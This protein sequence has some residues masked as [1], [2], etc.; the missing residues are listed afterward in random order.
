MQHRVHTAVSAALDK[1]AFDLDVLAVAG[2]TSIADYFLMCSAT[3]ERQAVAIADSVV[4]RLR[5]EDRVKPRLVEG[6]T[7]GRWI[8]LDYG[9][10]IFHIFTEDCRRFYGLER[11][12]GDAPNVTADFSEEA[13]PAN[14]R[15]TKTS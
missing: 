1:K 7:P 12:W 10:F 2:L 9:D 8:L 11:L 4:D 5:E 3:S 15:R 13:A 14:V 6:T